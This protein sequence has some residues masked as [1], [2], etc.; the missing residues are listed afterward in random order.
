[1]WGEFDVADS[2]CDPYWGSV[3]NGGCRKIDTRRYTATI[4]RAR[5]WI[6]DCKRTPLTVQGHLYATPSRCG[7]DALHAWGEFDVTDAVCEPHFGTATQMG[8]ANGRMLYQATL[9]DVP[10][11]EDAYRQCTSGRWKATIPGAGLTPPAS[12]APTDAYAT[13]YRGD[14]YSS[15]PLCTPKPADDKSKGTETSCSTSGVSEVILANT[16]EHEQ[17]PWVVDFT[18]NL[19]TKA[20]EHIAPGVRQKM[21]EMPEDGHRFQAALISVAAVESWNKD[22]PSDKRDPDSSGPQGA[23]K[24]ASFYDVTLPVLIAC[25]GSGI[26]YDSEQAAF[27]AVSPARQDSLPLAP[28]PG[29]APLRPRIVIPKAH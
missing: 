10:D 13:A 12:C 24:S 27:I 6:G 25:K 14:F 9:S 21:K 5:D 4:Q 26:G 16:T 28:K 19:L 22:H 17:V 20:G 8:C 3:D 1:M 29:V 7:Q 2:A 18:T 11:Q 15:D 23:V